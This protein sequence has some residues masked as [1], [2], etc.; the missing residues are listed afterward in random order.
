[1]LH[2]IINKLPENFVDQHSQIFLLFLVKSLANDDDQKVRSM[3]GAAIKLLVER[4]STRCGDSIIQYCLTWYEG[5]NSNLWS[6]AAQVKLLFC[7][8]ILFVGKF[9]T[10]S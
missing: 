4:V 5:G 6:I 9:P 7:S 2:A 1:M 3:A 8:I 10:R